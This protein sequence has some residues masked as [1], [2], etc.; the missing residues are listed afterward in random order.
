M[1]LAGVGEPKAAKHSPALCAHP[2]FPVLCFG[3]VLISDCVCVQS[4]PVERSSVDKQ[5]ECVGGLVFGWSVGGGVVRGARC[6]AM[7]AAYSG[8]SW[9]YLSDNTLLRRRYSCFFSQD[10]SCAASNRSWSNRRCTSDELCGAPPHTARSSDWS[11]THQQI[12]Y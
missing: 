11:P 10:K 7:W 8:V 9:S 12:M 5:G 1:S 4:V 3:V 2:C 6:G